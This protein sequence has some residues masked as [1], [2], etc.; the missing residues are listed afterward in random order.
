MSNDRGILKEWFPLLVY[1]EQIE[2]VRQKLEECGYQ[3]ALCMHDKDTNEDGTL[4]KVHWH[5]VVLCG[6]REFQYTLAKRLGIDRRFVQRPLATEPNGA[7]RYLTHLDNPEKAQY[8]RESIESNIT[9]ADLERLH[10]KVEKKSKD[11]ETEDLIEDIEKLAKKTMSYK[12]FLRAHPAFIYQAN[13][14][15]KLVSIAT[16]IQWEAVLDTQTGEMI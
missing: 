14:L 6:R 7:V 8:D 2:I 3:Y 16:D 13:S 10:Q 5:I 4:K 1:E 15:L 11:E 12:Q 9:P